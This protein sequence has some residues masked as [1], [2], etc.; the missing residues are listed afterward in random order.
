[1][2]SKVPPQFGD[3]LAA[4]GAAVRT[5]A[6]QFSLVA[7]SPTHSLRLQDAF[8]AGETAPYRLSSGP[9]RSGAAAITSSL[10]TT[11]SELESTTLD[12]RIAPYQ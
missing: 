3:E 8:W 9:N 7:K 2:A 4:E 10:P 1:M 12:E 6:M 5:N 11:R